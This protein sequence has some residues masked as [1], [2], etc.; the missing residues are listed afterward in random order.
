MATVAADGPGRRGR[1]AG[2]G[3][4]EKLPSG[5]LRVRWHDEDGQRRTAGQTFA[6]KADARRFLATVEADKLRGT[7]R[8]PR[9]VTDTLG[10][11]GARWIEDRPRLKASTR[12]QY[13]VDFRLH[14]EPALGSKV[15]D[16]IEPDDVRRW[17]S[18]LSDG[19]RASLAESGRNG[20]ATVARSYRLLRAILQ[21]AVEDDI[22]E[23]NPCRIPS[24]GD[25]R[26]PERPVL[27]AQEI[28]RLAD[29]VPLS[30]RAFVL[31]AGFT[32]L[33]AGEI[34]AL[35]LSDLDL[36]R[37][38]AVLRVTR[39]FYRVAGTLTVDT[40]KSEAGART[41]PLPAFVAD[42]LRAH[43]AE[44][45]PD[46]GP[47]DLVFVTS[48]GRDVLDGYSQ[49]VR[50]ALDRIGRTDARAHDL[51]HSA[52]TSAAEHG[53][54]LATLMQMAGHSTP[55][56]AQRYQHATLEHSRRVA[57][58]VDQSSAKLVAKSRTTRRPDR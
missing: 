56:A 38:S 4:I 44:F 7:Y 58:A 55:D 54:T 53:A 6:T 24:A 43:L 41:L 1:S 27:S 45:R 28:G 30:Y 33:R 31:V 16:Q 5:R 3:S 36:R 52:L 40:P 34:A 20:S 19:L 17:Y 9:V 51:R 39:R 35:R 57:A 13:E 37:G 26:S 2:F 15:L 50:R 14:I 23:R 25:A 29:E 11:Y 18:R 47:S 32:G 12:H 21:T 22:L 49:V 10:D 46:A 8:A 42:E 48:G